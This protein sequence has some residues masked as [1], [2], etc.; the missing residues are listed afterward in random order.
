VSAYLPYCESDVAEEFGEFLT[1]VDDHL[2]AVRPTATTVTSPRK[3]RYLQRQR[4]EY[5]ADELYADLDTRLAHMDSDGVAAEVL[6]HGGSNFYPIPFF[7][8]SVTATL[9]QDIPRT[10]EARRLRAAGIR[11]YNRWLADWT[12]PATDR[13]IGLAHLPIWD[14]EASIAEV[15]AAH[16]SGLRGINLPAPRRQLRGYNH[17]SWDPL[18]TV[19]ADLEMTM[20]THGGGGEIFP[21]S[22][23]G[24][25]GIN[26]SEVC[27]AGRRGLWQLI[28]GGVFQRFPSL[29][30]FLTEQSGAWVSDTLRTMD[31]AY[32]CPTQ[33]REAPYIREVLPHLPSEYFAMNCLIGGSFMSRIEA[34]AAVEEGYWQSVTWGRDYPHAEG[35]WPYTAAHLAHTFAGIEEDKVRA[36][37]GESAVKAVGLDH[38]RLSDISRRIGPRFAQLQTPVA[39]V[40]EGAE[41]S[42]GFRSIGSFA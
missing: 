1:H 8:K 5:G 16:R 25:M 20:H 26:L 2:L 18:W 37:L 41:L 6:F 13:L 10:R 29:R 31:S 36:I 35:T 30:F 11:M 9:S 28:F 14:L 3:E 42:F 12:T 15:R 32:L 39:P 24:S 22:G 38:A 23:P 34:Q 4:D 19:C 40:P 17:P 27:F 33:D 21:T 7:G